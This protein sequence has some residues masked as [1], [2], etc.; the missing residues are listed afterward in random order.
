MLGRPSDPLMWNTKKPDN[1]LDLTQCHIYYEVDPIWLWIPYKKVWLQNFS[2]ILVITCPHLYGITEIMNSEDSKQEVLLRWMKFQRYSICPISSYINDQKM[3][4]QIYVY[5]DFIIWSP[6]SPIQRY[7]SSL[8]TKL[9]ISLL[10]LRCIWEIALLL[11]YHGDHF[12][13]GVWR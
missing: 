8:L 9:I 11:G 5:M 7:N 10:L 3:I 4:L 13:T 12:P 1:E 2:T 6:F